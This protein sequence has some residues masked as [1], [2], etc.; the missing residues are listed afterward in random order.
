MG[1][2]QI[3]WEKTF[4]ATVIRAITDVYIKLIKVT[5]RRALCP[6]IILKLLKLQTRNDPMTIVMTV[7]IS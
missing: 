3:Q 1:R 5:S 6:L 2:S 7:L 4:N